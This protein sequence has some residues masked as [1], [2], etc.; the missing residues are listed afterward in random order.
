VPPLSSSYAIPKGVF[1]SSGGPKLSTSYQLQGTSG[2]TTGTGVRVSDSYRL[3][4]GYWNELACPQAEL[5]AAPD[6]S[7]AGTAVTLTWGAVAGASSYRI[8]RGVEPYFPLGTPY[9]TTT[10]VTW[11]D[12][13]GAGDLLVNHT[14]VIKAVNACSES[15]VLY[16]VAEYDF[17]LTP[18]N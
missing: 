13:S 10:G 11:M 5:A 7:A 8:Y 4:S 15:S 3:R 16:R 12:P 2:Q 9:D 6:I 1:G 18:G 14:Y 17:A